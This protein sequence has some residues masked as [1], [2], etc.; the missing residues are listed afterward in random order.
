LNNLNLLSIQIKEIIEVTVPNLETKLG[1]LKPAHSF[2]GSI[3]KYYVDTYGFAPDC[4]VIA[5][6]G[7]NPNSLAAL[8]LGIVCNSFIVICT[9]LSIFAE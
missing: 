7:D 9:S 1:D 2:V 8:R 3:A 4:H 6:S 5:F